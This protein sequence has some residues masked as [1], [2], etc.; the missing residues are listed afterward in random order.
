MKK[1][2]LLA[3]VVAFSFASVAVGQDQTSPSDATQEVAPA[4]AAPVAAETQVAAPVEAA[5]MT[6]LQDPVAVDSVLPMEGAVAP[7]A[8]PVA[9]GG[10]CGAAAPVAQPCC[11]QAPAVNNCCR[12]PRTRVLRVVRRPFFGRFRSRGNCCN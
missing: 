12:T 9:S 7:Q 4:A 10:C 6:V 8:G 2:S 5:P 1:F 3:L 11:G